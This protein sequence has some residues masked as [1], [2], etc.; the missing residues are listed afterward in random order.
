VDATG[1]TNKIAQ[2]LAS[3]AQALS[4]VTGKFKVDRN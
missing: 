2:D 3:V 4:T 1:R